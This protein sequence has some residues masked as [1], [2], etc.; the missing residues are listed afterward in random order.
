[1]WF[2]ER[3]LLLNYFK[4]ASRHLVRRF[5]YFVFLLADSPYFCLQAVT[6]SQ[7]IEKEA[8]IRYINNIHHLQNLPIKMQTIDWHVSIKKLMKTDERLKHIKKLCSLR[9]PKIGV[10]YQYLVNFMPGG[11][12]KL[13][14]LKQTCSWKPLLKYLLLFTT[15]RDWLTYV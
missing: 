5:C 14:L 9:Q 13:H 2:C 3:F 15:I 6:R 8:F 4:Y 11:N 12:K 1:M 7:A 10:T